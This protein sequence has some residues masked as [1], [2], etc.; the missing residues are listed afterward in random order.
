MKN[1]MTRHDT[2]F[3]TNSAGWP[4]KRNSP[5]LGVQLLDTDTVRLNGLCSSNLYRNPVSMHALKEGFKMT[6]ATV[7]QAFI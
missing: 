4:Q 7:R 3:D 1:Y 2:V 5:D 6:L